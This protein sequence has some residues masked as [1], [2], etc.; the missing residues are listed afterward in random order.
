MSE[1]NVPAQSQ[2]NAEQIDGTSSPQANAIS[3][4]SDQNGTGTLA[5]LPI[6][7]IDLSTILL[8]NAV[9]QQKSAVIDTGKLP[10]NP[11]GA[12]AAATPTKAAAVQEGETPTTITMAKFGASQTAVSDVGLKAKVQVSADGEE[13]VQTGTATS[14]QPEVSSLITEIKLSKTGK[15]SG[16]SSGDQT[17]LSNGTKSAAQTP[18]PGDKSTVENIAGAAFTQASGG[19]LLTPVAQIVENIRNAVTVQRPVQADAASPPQPVKTLEI[20]LQPEGLGAVTVT[21][22]SDQGKM[23]V[24]ISAKED[25]TRQELERNSAEL[26]NG[27]QKV[28]ATFKDAD[29]NF[30]NQNQ[31]GTQDP[32]GQTFGNGSSNGNDRRPTPDFVSGSGANGGQ[33]ASQSNAQSR[34]PAYGTQPPGKDTVA[35]EQPVGPGR[36]DGI[37]L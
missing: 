34:N 19:K 6:Q 20:Q 15:D 12:P 36:A 22:K 31:G 32:K 4:K 37:Y 13:A 16:S 28:D 26:V 23:K 7:T 25:S 18:A 17:D 14:P 11:A 24:Q 8:N 9:S 30:S 27:L 2:D 21:L 5:R 29:V 1:Q 3:S 33:D 35:G 10:T